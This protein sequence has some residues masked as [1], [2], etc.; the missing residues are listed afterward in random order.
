MSAV[1]SLCCDQGHC[2]REGGPKGCGNRPLLSLASLEENPGL[3]DLKLKQFGD[4]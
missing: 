3:G 1:L 2:E 4:P